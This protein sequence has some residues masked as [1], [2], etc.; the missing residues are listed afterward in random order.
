[1]ASEEIMEEMSKQLGE[2]KQL[3]L[4]MAR[5]DIQKELETIITT[6]E[7]KKIWALCDGINTTTEISNKAKVSIRYVQVII[8][9]LQNANLVSVE[10]R[11]IPKRVFDYVPKNW[12]V[13]NVE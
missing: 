3:L 6:D 2:I 4:V 5:G 1:M 9:D 8:K 7:K 10:K 11:G 13:K 12:R